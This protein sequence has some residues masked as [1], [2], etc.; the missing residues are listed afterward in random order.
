MKYYQQLDKALKSH[1]EFRPY[2]QYSIDWICDR[3][4]WCWRWKKITKEQMEELALRA[5]NILEGN[6]P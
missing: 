2:H 3:I 4:T 5:T 6:L 1:E